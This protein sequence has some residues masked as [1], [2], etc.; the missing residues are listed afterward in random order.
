MPISLYLTTPLL[1][2]YINTKIIVKIK[3]KNMEKTAKEKKR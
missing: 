2:K 3:S 1:T